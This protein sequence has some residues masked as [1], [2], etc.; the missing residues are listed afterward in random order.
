MRWGMRWQ[1]DRIRTM[2]PGRCDQAF[3]LGA[4]ERRRSHI[5]LE[6]RRGGRLPSLVV[7]PK[8]VPAEVPGHPKSSQN[9][10]QDAL[11][12][13]RGAQERP[14]SITGAS[15]ERLGTSP[16]RPG[17][18]R[19]VTKGTP[20]RQKGRPG[21]SRSAPRRPKSTKIAGNELIKNS[22]YF[23]LFFGWYFNSAG[24]EAGLKTLIQIRRPDGRPKNLTTNPPAGR[25]A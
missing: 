7:E 23:F 11:G 4:G 22:N 9:R 13:P 20:G 18:A 17:S 8:S 25:P 24:R 12:T 5:G 19:G 3:Q 1:P 14:G 10:S 21:A 16:G 6:R 15:Q 2:R